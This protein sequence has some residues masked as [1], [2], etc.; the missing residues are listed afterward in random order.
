MRSLLKTSCVC[1]F[2]MLFTTTAFSQRQN[3]NNQQIGGNILH[4][5]IT[6][7]LEYTKESQNIFDIA[8]G[9]QFYDIEFKEAKIST[10][11]TLYKVRYNAFLDEMEIMQAN[12]IAC[13]NKNLQKH[14]ISF[15][16]D[17]LEYKI[18]E[19]DNRNKKRV[20]GY[21]E[22]LLENNK[23]SLYKKNQKKLAIGLNRA[24]YMTPAPE[25]IV[26]FQDE[27]TA[28]YIELNNSG[29]AI[30]LPR[31]R[32]AV[33]RLFKGKEDLVKKFIKENNIKVTKEDDLKKL[34]S[35]VNSL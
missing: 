22:V 9:S 5:N 6:S 18:L 2:V 30:K 13:I 35:Y 7:P 29:N 12:E 11:E 21:F 33:I 28:F 27:K 15:P 24:P 3:S 25:K 10:S 31:K 32:K 20:H 23:V 34:I 8:E 14:K 4:N 1:A 16:E 19:A 26:E 17:N